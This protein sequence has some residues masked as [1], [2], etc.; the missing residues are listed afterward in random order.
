MLIMPKP[1]LEVGEVICKK[2]KGKGTVLAQDVPLIIYVLNQRVPCPVCN[3]K[4]KTLVCLFAI[5]YGK[6]SKLTLMRKAD[7]QKKN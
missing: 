2:C 4:G 6:K 5:G 7:A 1:K 3:G